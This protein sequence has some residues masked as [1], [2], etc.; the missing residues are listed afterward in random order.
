MA[1]V[2]SD[3]RMPVN[4]YTGNG[5]YVLKNAGKKQDCGVKDKKDY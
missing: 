5:F 2:H 4:R 3:G 1:L